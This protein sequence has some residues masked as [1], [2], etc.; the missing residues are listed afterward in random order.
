MGAGGRP[1][2]AERPRPPR[3]SLERPGDVT[4]TNAR[5]RSASQVGSS[6][7]CCLFPGI[8]SF[9]PVAANS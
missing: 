1:Q 2:I 9:Y 8:D 7:V 3:H 5:G 4:S 6:D